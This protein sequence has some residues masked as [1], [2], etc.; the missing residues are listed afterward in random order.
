MSGILSG[1]DVTFLYPDLKIGIA[2]TFIHGKMAIGQTCFLRS[3]IAE[4]ALLCPTFTL[5]SG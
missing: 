2:G 1:E 5:G 4:E 3:V